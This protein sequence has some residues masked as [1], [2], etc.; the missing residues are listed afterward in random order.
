MGAA[1]FQEV[2]TAGESRL[3]EL[4]GL[5]ESGPGLSERR[6]PT[7]IPELYRA[8]REERRTLVDILWEQHRFH[9]SRRWN[10]VELVESVRP[11]NLTDL[12]R[13]VVWSAGR[14]EM[15]AKPS[16]D[17]MARLADVECRRWQGKDDALASVIQALGSWSRYWNEEESHHEMGFSQLALQLGFEPLSDASVIDYR[18][19]FPDDDLLRTLTMLSFSEGIA[20]VNYGQYARHVRD[21]SLRM[22]IK[23]VGADEVQ[24][25]QYFIS[26]AK[27]LADSG[28]YAPKESFA[29]AHLFLREGGELYGSSRAHVE[30]RGTHTNWWDHLE[31]G[32]GKAAAAPEALERKRT[33]I[34]HALKRI[35]GISC[36]SPQE[37][38]DVWMD[39]VGD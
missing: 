39:L 23:Q 36:S 6:R 31:D 11:E 18:K 38:E 8:F 4:S 13:F 29:V 21:P 20:A 25:M 1:F 24:H 19:V 14:A 28:A 33:L 16:A 30:Y 2:S 15:T 10:A 12:D 5:S 7:V 17:R 34:L 9:E 3:F 37:V 22:L 26:F 35:T 27:A 32:A